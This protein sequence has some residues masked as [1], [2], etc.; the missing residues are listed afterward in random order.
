LTY[1][2]TYLP[3]TLAPSPP[4]SFLAMLV[5]T[6][7]VRVSYAITAHV[8]IDDHVDGGRKKKKTRPGS[9][10]QGPK[11]CQKIRGCVLPS[12]GWPCGLCAKASNI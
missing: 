11:T 6:T 5:W 9:Q 12:S 10:S 3:T 7:Q 8:V 1:L 4:P 2:P